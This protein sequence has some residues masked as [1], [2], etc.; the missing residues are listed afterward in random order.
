MKKIKLFSSLSALAIIGTSAPIMAT[1]CS[2]STSTEYSISGINWNEAPTVGTTSYANQWYISNG[3][4]IIASHDD[5]QNISNIAINKDTA[6]DLGCNYDETLKMWFITPTSYGSLKLALDITLKD[7]TKFTVSTTVMVNSNYPWTVTV[8]KNCNIDTSTNRVEILN[9]KEDAMINVSAADVPS[10]AEYI[11]HAF[12]QD[13]HIVEFELKDGVLTIPA[14]TFAVTDED[15]FI[16]CSIS[17]KNGDHHIGSTMYMNIT[18]RKVEP[19]IEHGIVT[20]V[21][22]TNENNTGV[23]DYLSVPHTDTKIPDG[24]NVPINDPNEINSFIYEYV[25]AETIAEGVM[26]RAFELLQDYQLKDAIVNWKTITDEA[27]STVTFIIAASFTVD[28]TDNTGT[29]YDK[30]LAF[31]QKLIEDTKDEKVTSFEVTEETLIDGEITNIYS[32]SGTEILALLNGQDPESSY[33]YGAYLA[34]PFMGKSG[35]LPYL[36]LSL[37]EFNG[38]MGLASVGSHIFYTEDMLTSYAYNANFPVADT[39][40][41]I[42]IKSDNYKTECNNL[43]STTYAGIF[44]DGLAQDGI[45]EAVNVVRYYYTYPITGVQGYTIW[46]YTTNMITAKVVVFVITKFGALPYYKTLNFTL[47][48]S[49]V[50]TLTVDWVDLIDG[51]EEKTATFNVASDSSDF[52][53]VKAI[54]LDDEVIGYDINLKND[55]SETASV[56]IPAKDYGSKLTVTEW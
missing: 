29:H 52:E 55:N 8:G 49:K 50:S 18:M 53:N 46:N 44:A 45:N 37:N 48:N 47:N 22:W 19:V 33:M 2:C 28:Y 17:I 32:D 20:F 10:T 51:G 23:L 34:I 15:P 5:N 7:N 13:E 11:V 35:I 21:D 25:C 3:N 1:S 6:K 36:Y 26:Q 38:G 24:Y 39:W 14:N 9:V 43:L 31:N 56:R 42:N 4:K 27:K 41:A 40:T 30:T 16:V 54:K 12:N